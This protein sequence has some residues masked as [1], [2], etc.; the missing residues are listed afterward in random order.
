M[1]GGENGTNGSQLLVFSEDIAFSLHFMAP[2]TP[3]NSASGTGY[4]SKKLSKIAE[5]PA[6]YPMHGRYSELL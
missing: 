5:I 1:C 2:R 4:A 3:H 6:S